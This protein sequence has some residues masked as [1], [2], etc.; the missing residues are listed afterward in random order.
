MTMA[1]FYIPMALS[2]SAN[3]ANLPPIHGLYAFAIQPLVGELEILAWVTQLTGPRYTRFSDL[4]L[5]WLLALRLLGH[6]SWARQ[7]G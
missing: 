4:V 6:S 5:L 1:S 3:L 7:F 2:L